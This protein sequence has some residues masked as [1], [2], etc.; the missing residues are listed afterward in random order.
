MSKF[1]KL[2][3]YW[4]C[5]I[6]I[7]EHKVNVFIEC[8]KEGLYL[9]AFTHDSSKFLPS[10]FF[11]YAEKFHSQTY[12]YELP[13]KEKKFKIAWLYHQRRNKHHWDYWVNSEGIALDMPAKYIKQMVCDWRGVS[14]K[15]GDTPLS[16]Y[17]KNRKDINISTNTFHILSFYL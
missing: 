8:F 13:D 12:K 9:H 7:I 10:E 3:I 4:T 6:Y 15:F 14:R 2:K 1:S 16:F 11:A 17:N 5:F